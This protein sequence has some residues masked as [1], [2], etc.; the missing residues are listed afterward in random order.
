[1]AS[2]SHCG[3]EFRLFSIFNRGDMQALCRNWRKRHERICASRSPAQR[4]AWAKKYLARD[5]AE[6]SLTV[7]IRHPGFSDQ[8]PHLSL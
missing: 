3:A 2:C 6:S 8:Q 1:M 5:P 4:R 7:D